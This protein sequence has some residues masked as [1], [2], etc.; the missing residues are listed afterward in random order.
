MLSYA[1]IAVYLLLLL[2]YGYISK[3]QATKREF[4]LAGR[5]MK[6]LPVL[7]SI[8]ATETS[9]ASLLLFPDLGFNPTHRF[10]FLQLAA[11]MAIG[12]LLSARLLIGP[13]YRSGKESVY[14]ILAEKLSPGL[15]D[16]GAALYAVSTV[17]AAGVRLF[18]GAI[19]LSILLGFQSLGGQ[20]DG[21]QTAI[22]NLQIVVFIIA[23]GAIA[24]YYSRQGGLKAVIYTDNFQFLLI[25]SALFGI[26]LLQFKT[27]DPG[28]LQWHDFIRTAPGPESTWYSYTYSLPLALIGGIVLSLGSHGIDQTTIQRVLAQ[29]SE[30]EAKKSIIYSAYAIVPFI[31]LYLLCGYVISQDPSG[32][33]M[34]D[35]KQYIYPWYLRNVDAPWLTALTCV[36]FLSAAMSSIDSALHSMATSL[37]QTTFRFAEKIT[38]ERLTLLSGF[39]LILS[40]LFFQFVKWINPEATLISLALGATGMIF[41]PMAALYIM[42]FHF[43]GQ[44]QDSGAAAKTKSK[45]MLVA[46]LSGVLCNFVIFGLNNFYPVVNISWLLSLVLSF[47]ITALFIAA[48]LSYTRNARPETP[49]KKRKSNAGNSF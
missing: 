17:L 25:L 12:R 42:I 4:M 40:A 41:S 48:G 26:L 49:A 16:I 5:Q 32:R 22:G 30:A 13:V 11:G 36:A 39:C 15:A 8:L 7:L 23:G 9:A 20:N 33:H 29:R 28:A 46:L 35:T 14:E 21:G 18:I 10:I 47:F 3:G 27:V 37:K 19:A 1:F 45:V 38:I 24:M 6:T 31:F 2:S 44:G 34:Q 43:P